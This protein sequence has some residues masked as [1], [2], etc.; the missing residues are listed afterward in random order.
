MSYKR[1]V[2]GLVKPF[3]YPLAVEDMDGKERWL[4]EAA[5]EENFHLSLNEKM[6]REVIVRQWHKVNPSSGWS[7]R[8]NN[9]FSKKRVLKE[10]WKVKEEREQRLRDVVEGI[11]KLQSG[12]NEE[13]KAESL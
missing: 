11:E 12:S 6:E 10:I 5:L 9:H 2:V 1:V 4:R 8:N 3:Y 7:R 13:Q